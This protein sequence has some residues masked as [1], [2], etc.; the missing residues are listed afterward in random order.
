LKPAWA[1]DKEFNKIGV[2]GLGL[3]AY[4][5]KSTWSLGLRSHLGYY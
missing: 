4:D 3:L 2:I 1:V 5:C